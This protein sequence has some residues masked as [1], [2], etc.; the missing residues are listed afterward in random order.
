MHTDKWE[1]EVIDHLEDRAEQLRAKKQRDGGKLDE[2][3]EIRLQ[4]IERLLARFAKEANA[5]TPSR[6][7]H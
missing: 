3:D 5:L 7:R 1:R 6:T 4:V 2:D